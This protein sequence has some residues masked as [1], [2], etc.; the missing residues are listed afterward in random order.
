MKRL[1]FF[2]YG[3]LLPGQPNY[4][5]WSNSIEE[6]IPA[7]FKNGR[8]KDLGSY[9]ILLEGGDTPVLGMLISIRD[10]DYRLILNR[11]DGLEGFDQRNPEASPYKRVER[12]VTLDDNTLVNAWIYVGNPTMITGGTIIDT[13]NWAAYA[14]SKKIDVVKWWADW[15]IGKSK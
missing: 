12:L 7:T 1:P 6:Q 4:D 2:V 15:R 3:T 5:L 13:G 8:L 9:P 10:E 14:Q 11:L